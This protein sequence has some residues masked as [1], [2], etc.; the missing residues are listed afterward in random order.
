MQDREMIPFPM[1]DADM[2]RGD[3]PACL[4]L[5]A[6]RER[7]GV[8]VRSG[9]TRIRTGMLPVVI[10]ALV[11]FSSDCP[12]RV[13]RRSTTAPAAAAPSPATEP[14]QAAAAVASLPWLTRF[15]D[16]LDASRRTRQ[17]ILVDVGAE[18]CV[19]CRELDRAIETPAVQDRLRNWTRLRL[20]ADRDADAIHNLAVGPL[21]ALRVLAPNGQMLAWHN[22]SMTADELSSWLDAHAAQAGARPATELESSDPP[23][24]AAIDKVLDDLTDRDP[25]VHGA[26]ARRLMPW[27][28][29]AA[30]K[31]VAAFADGKLRQRVATKEVL[32]AWRAPVRTLDPW[33]PQTITPAAIDA[34]RKW[35]AQKH[36]PPALAMLSGEDLDIAR[37][38]IAAM[39]QA[40]DPA[41]VDSARERLA[42]FG[43]A[44]LP[45]VYAALKTANSDEVR[46]RLTALRYR[47][48]AT[49]ALALHWPGGFD[50][51]AS[52][53][54]PARH[55]AL[56]E[57][58]RQ[59]TAADAPLL[60]ELFSDPDPFMRETSLRLLQSTGGGAGNAGG[61]VR[62]LHDPE[63]NVRAAVL[64]Q[65][66]ETPDAQMVP[67]IVKYLSTEKDTDLIVHAIRFLREA[68]SKAAV[69]SLMSLLG[70]PSWRVRA[71]AAEGLGVTVERNSSS[72]SPDV[73][74]RQADIYAA[75]IKLLDDPDG[76]VVSRALGVLKGAQVPA[77]TKAIAAVAERR[78][79]LAADIVKTLGAQSNDATAQ[80]ALRRFAAHK[81]PGVRSAALAALGTNAT[82]D[83]L[84]P[85]LRDPVVRVRI[86]GA[87]IVEELLE[88]QRPDGGRGS[89]PNN[90]NV[91]WD[92]WLKKFRAGIGRA[93]WAAQMVEPLRKMLGSSDAGERLAAAIPLVALG[94]DRDATK[95]LH[96]A[97][98]SQP[99]ERR[100]VA[101]ALKWL[102]WDAR[103]A[104]FNDLKSAS[105]G[106]A[107]ML[108]VLAGD[109]A[110]TPSPNA[111]PPLWELLNDKAADLSVAAAVDRALIRT[112]TGQEYW[113][114]QQQSGDPAA[115]KA[116]IGTAKH[117][118][119]EGSANQRLVALAL[120][121]SASP[122]DAAA[123]AVAV[124]EG[125]K[126]GEGLGTAALQVLLL[127]QSREDGVKSALAHVGDASAMRKVALAYLAA[128]A[129][130]IRSIQGEL[131]L[132][133]NNPQLQFRTFG[134][135]VPIVIEP[136]AGVAPDAIRPY[137]KDADPEA[138]A[139]ASY[140]LCLMGERQG[141]DAVVAWWRGRRDDDTWRRLAYRAVAVVGDDNLT[142]VLDEI[143]AT[144][145]KS[146]GYEI[147]DFYWTIRVMKG[148][149][150]LKLRK[151]IRDEVGMENLR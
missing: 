58:G 141:L 119:A 110:G 105:A 101:G 131:Y 50:R 51:L 11:L 56:E 69:D 18:W 76:F 57:L 38:D 24:A 147:R 25:L 21:P 59:A 133:A 70:N 8:R 97:I 67:E 135:G 9:V 79:E 28:D 31:V 4:P 73:Q 61:L 62:L 72:S 134:E 80:D 71:E 37:H 7:V 23:D 137:A 34:L 99:N 150:V 115:R 84:L 93:D 81:D 26:A 60:M 47:A 91:D 52:T 53:D 143:Y 12:A 42:R 107:Q 145:D 1:M 19:W 136:P 149:Q 65:L 85:A 92:D 33:D 114:I 75:M 82:A 151:R 126:A 123:S 86:S 139:Y 13:V 66:T 48:V 129:E 27:P 104:L 43:P 88:Q 118:A 96:D 78:P 40:S 35:A 146:R 111:G 148:E 144:Y 30:A 68:R 109:L 39:L 116:M 15:A 127:S 6:F 3:A 128:G 46:E 36:E 49:E 32:L 16:A 124:L 55:A 117:M 108:G 94:D 64:K 83:E 87:K 138:A 130:P 20:D 132:N 98:R 45:E 63:P 74:E 5:P 122:G 120:L 121:E 102:P 106:D 100:T 112:Y 140:L 77:A 89:R 103:L 22:G 29:Q 41:E 54:A 14:S 17:P 125:G 2:A 10:A 44:L 90:G 113:Y 142:P 95:A